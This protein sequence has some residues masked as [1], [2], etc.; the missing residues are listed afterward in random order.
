MTSTETDAGK[1]SR[2]STT[3][4]STLKKQVHPTLPLQSDVIPILINH[5]CDQGGQMADG[6]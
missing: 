4:S 5:K 1:L 6:S 3:H 2:E